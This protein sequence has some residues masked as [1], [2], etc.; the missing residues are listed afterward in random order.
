METFFIVVC[1]G[2]VIFVYSNM[3]KSK[4]QDIFDGNSPIIN[5]WILEKGGLLASLLCATYSDHSLT[6]NS[7]ATIFVGKFNRK[8][9]ESSGFYIEI[10]NGKVILD[11]QYFPDGIT[12]WHKSLSRDAKLHGI[13][14]YEILNRAEARHHEE[15][16]KWKDVK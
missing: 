4:S 1:V 5:K 14:L 8:H 7:G 12:S 3:K 16:P 2:I 13:T 9:G 10:H 6:V 11:K 15:F